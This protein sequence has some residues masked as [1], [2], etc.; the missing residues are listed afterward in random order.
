MT[1][2]QIDS[3]I[4]EFKEDLVKA[5]QKQPP[6]FISFAGPQAGAADRGLLVNMVA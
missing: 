3:K 6:A 1:D 2:D 5:V 4:E